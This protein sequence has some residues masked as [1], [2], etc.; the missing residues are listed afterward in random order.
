VLALAATST[1][2]LAGCTSDL[3]HER[4]LPWGARIEVN[5]AETEILPDGDVLVRAPVFNHGDGTG[6]VRLHAVLDF[7]GGD[8]YE[9]TRDVTLPAG[10]ER[11]Y[12]L[13]FDLSGEDA[14]EASVEV[15]LTDPDG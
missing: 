5:P 11:T 14:Q 9:K 12:E 15:F 13:E 2:A 7:E 3:G 6:T 4:V 10:R 8:T 1:A